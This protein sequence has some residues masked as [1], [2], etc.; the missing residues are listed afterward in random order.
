LNLLRVQGPLHRA[1]LARQ[2]GVS[3]TTVSTIVNELIETGLVRSVQD[4]AE[5]G[6]TR[7]G[8]PGDL[9]ALNLSGQV[10]VGM[11]YSFQRVRVVVADLAHTVLAEGVSHLDPDQGWESTLAAGVAVVDAA[12]FEAGM[13]RSAVLG[14]G[15]GIPGPVDSRSGRVGLSSNVG[16]AGVH[17]ADELAARLELPVLVDN[18]AHL[19]ALAEVVWGAGVGC[20]D[21][22]YVLLS[23]GIGGGLILNDQIVRGVAGSAGELGHLT[24]DDA[25]PTCRCG[26]RGCLEAYA[27]VPAILSALR[28]VLGEDITLGD[29]LEANAN[30]SRAARRVFGDVGQVVGRTLGGVCNLFNPER[31]LIGGDVARAGEVLLEALRDSLAR[32][33]LPI[34]ADSVEVVSAK[35]D[36]Q[37]GA[38]GGVALVL[39]SNTPLLTES[40]F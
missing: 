12:L 2:A 14:V 33:S 40:A 29:A 34:A 31:I 10:V 15:V 11:D 30:G 13:S 20:H 26:N 22:I 6:A 38:L 23:T 18:N 27:G 3:R 16:W 1:E 9:L 24:V 25:G 7:Q 4:P 36:D 37:A 21:L 35:L 28:P 8:R 5:S 17:P 39:R 19:A 32:H